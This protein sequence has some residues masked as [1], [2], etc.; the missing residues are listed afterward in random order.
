M[1]LIFDHDSFLKKK[2]G[3]AKDQLDAIK[4]QKGRQYKLDSFSYDKDSDHFFVSLS[5]Q[6]GNWYVFQ[7]HVRIIQV[8]KTS[9]SKMFSCSDKTIEEFYLP[10]NRTMSLY[11][12]FKGNRLNFF[13]AQI[14][15]ESGQ[16]IYTKE[17]ASGKAYEGRKDLGNTQPG[18][19]VKFKGRGLIQLTG[20]FNYQELSKDFGV[21][22]VNNP[23][24]LETPEWASRSAGWFWDKKNLNLISDTGDFEKVTRTIN[25]GLNGLADR[26]HLLGL[27]QKA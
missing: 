20:R 4:V 22:F 17:L 25:G 3:Q 19:G 12:I 1:F 14:G 13:L 5:F 27:I 9:L 8:S 7:P 15:H 21:D 11:N 6:A 24:L 23:E 16:L 26:R 2:T 10:L 18:D